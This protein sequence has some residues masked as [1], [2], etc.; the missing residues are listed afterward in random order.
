M[1]P[2][3]SNESNESHA[4]YGSE[5]CLV[6]TD[7]LE[8]ILLFLRNMNLFRPLK[9]VSANKGVAHVKQ[10]YSFWSEYGKLLKKMHY[11]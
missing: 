8:L 2:I 6:R 7:S 11:L 3:N 9:S 5:Y 1:K 10:R 4:V